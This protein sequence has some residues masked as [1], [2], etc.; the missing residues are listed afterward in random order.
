MLINVIHTKNYYLFFFQLSKES[1]RDIFEFMESNKMS[2][3][4]FKIFS[5]KTYPDYEE[6]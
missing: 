4:K 5:G 1:A 3:S 2:V 6:I